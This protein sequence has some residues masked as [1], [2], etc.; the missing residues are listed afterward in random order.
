MWGKKSVVKSIEDKI[1]DITNIATNTSLNAKINEVENEIPTIINLPTTTARKSKINK[2]ANKLSS[3]TILATTAALTAVVNKISRSAQ[4]NLAS[5][6]ILLI[7]QKRQIFGDTLKDLN[8]NV[9]SNKTTHVLVENKSNEL[10]EKVQ[11]R[12]LTD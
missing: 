6:G 4:A 7:S 1:F 12:S 10:P 3:T 8:K 2:V 9:T 11:E 5:K